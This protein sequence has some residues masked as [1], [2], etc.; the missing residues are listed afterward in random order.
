MRDARHTTRVRA[1]AFACTALVSLGLVAGAASAA[2]QAQMDAVERSQANVAQPPWPEGDERGMANTLGAGTWSRCAY[3]MT[4]ANAQSF[5][6]SHER[7]N[8]MPLSPFGV[9]L[10]YEFN[11]SVFDPR[12]QTCVQR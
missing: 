12:H 4:A 11:P 8:T 1:F 7:S 10:Q 5:E 2:D 3:H 6:L 9:P